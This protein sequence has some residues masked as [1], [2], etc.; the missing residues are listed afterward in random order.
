M[1]ERRALEPVKHTVPVWAVKLCCVVL[2]AAMLLAAVAYSPQWRQLISDLAEV[3]RQT[4]A[5]RNPGAVWI[6]IALLAA[7]LVQL[8]QIRR[9]GARVTHS[10]L[11]TAVCAPRAAALGGDELDL[12]ARHEAGHA[13][14]A[15]QC[16]VQIEM[17][18]VSSSRTAI[19]GGKIVLPRDSGYRS[20]QQEWQ[21]IQISWGGEAA[22]RHAGIALTGPSGADIDDALHAAGRLFNVFADLGF[23]FT[24]P[25]DLSRQGLDAARVI[26]EHQHE[27]IEAVVALFLSRIDQDIPG[28]DITEVI[29]KHWKTAPSELPDHP[30][31]RSTA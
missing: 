20:W 26:V 7:I 27:A 16:G 1:S 31:E 29:E 6:V 17:G 28:P 30:A 24:S 15:Y 13:V 22:Q 23:V 5:L 2:G 10:E 11:P 4:V 19:L 3:A 18:H 25:H 8:R 14:V 9:R 12:R 21:A